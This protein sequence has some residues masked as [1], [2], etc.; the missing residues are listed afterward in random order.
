MCFSM[1]KKSKYSTKVKRTKQNNSR[2]GELE[3]ER[4]QNGMDFWTIC[5]VWAC[6]ALRLLWIFNFEMALITWVGKQLC[7]VY[8]LKKIA[9]NFECIR[10]VNVKT[11][12]KKSHLCDWWKKLIVSAVFYF[13]MCS[14][15]MSLNFMY[16]TAYE[17]AWLSTCNDLIDEFQCFVRLK[18]NSFKIK[19]MFD[20]IMKI[21]FLKGIGN[22]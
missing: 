2:I 1:Q 13:K 14:I 12:M 16:A 5:L 10:C 17:R 7:V 8:I 15:Q 21:Q 18:L 9:I 11:I 6:V 22:R 19:A 20:E 4:G 3:L